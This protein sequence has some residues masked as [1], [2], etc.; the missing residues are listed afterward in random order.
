MPR[1]VEIK[2]RVVDL[3]ALEKRVAEIAGC[4]PEILVQDDTFFDCPQGRLKL[5]Q[6]PDGECELIFY[7]R[8][9]ERGP[10]TSR[11]WIARSADPDSLREVLGR[12]LG[13][14]G[15]I[16]K[17]RRLYRVG[18]TRV[19]LDEV[20]QLGE[21]IELEVVLEADE[22][23]ERGTAIAAGLMRQLEIQTEQLLQGAYLDLLDGRTSPADS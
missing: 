13:Q 18:Q 6:F 3:P 5:R 1:N 19:H 14:I 9:D 15:R 16:R 2:A 17:R 7:Q 20:D 22:A 11:Y 21:F 8:S 10:K 12:A 23:E 4:G